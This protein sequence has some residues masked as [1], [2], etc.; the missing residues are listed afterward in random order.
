MSAWRGWSEEQ[1]RGSKVSSSGFTAINTS[2]DDVVALTS[3]QDA[4]QQGQSHFHITQ[5]SKTARRAVSEYLGRDDAQPT[6][7]VTRTKGRKRACLTRETTN[8]SKCRRLSNNL[9][10]DMS[11]A[12][13]DFTAAPVR[14]LGTHHVRHAKQKKPSKEDS[15]KDDHTRTHESDSPVGKCTSLPPADAM[16]PVTIHGQTTTMMQ[17]LD[18]T[19]VHTSIES[20]KGNDGQGYTEYHSSSVSCQPPSNMQFSQPWLNTDA[21]ESKTSQAPPSEL[22]GHAV[23]VSASDTHLQRSGR[24]AKLVASQKNSDLFLQ[25]VL[26]ESN[27]SQNVPELL[28]AQAE[29]KNHL[30]GRHPILERDRGLVPPVGLIDDDDDDFSE[31]DEQTLEDLA[32][33]VEPRPRTPPA[34]NHKQNIREVDENEDYGGALLSVAEIELLGK[35]L[36]VLLRVLVVLRLTSDKPNSKHPKIL[37][38]PS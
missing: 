21:A 28:P 33:S 23:D 7:P 4:L 22:Q 8:S 17:A 27:T 2:K 13:T 35:W 32:K 36:S 26:E 14:S 11:I 31:L 6:V 19:S 9:G 34:R 16:K 3:N 25:P 18:P 1:L 5:S 29:N 24:R 37:C 30:N 20:L 12:T 10:R 38:S 15:K